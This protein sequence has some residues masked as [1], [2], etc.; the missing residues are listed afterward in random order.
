MKKV[1]SE[2]RKKSGIDLWIIVIVTGVALFAYTL[3]HSSFVGTIKNT[4][5]PVI[6]RLLYA[7]SFQF[8]IAGL[9]VTIVSIYRKEP[10]AEHGLVWNN[11][12][13]TVLLSIPC[14]IPYIA[15]VYIIKGAVTYCPF[16][17]VYTTKEILSS[18]FPT[19][20][21]GMS[22]TA[23]IWGFF[24]GFN[25]VV[26]ADKI[27]ALYPPKKKWMNWGAI[28]CAI[29]CVLIHGA[30]GVSAEGFLETIAVICIIYGMLIVKEYTGNAWGV[31]MIFVLFWNAV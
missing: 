8:G 11:L 31:A 6:L 29:M 19:N 24:E 22:I 2:K 16:Q 18:S 13:K 25:Y 14:I 1:L 12:V 10:F 20:A 9:G 5:I 21:L 28:I 30:V 15:F 4:D 3:V 26:I 23:V 27:N 17:T 7:A